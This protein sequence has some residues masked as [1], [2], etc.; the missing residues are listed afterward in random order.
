MAEETKKTAQVFRLV[1]GGDMRQTVLKD[2][3]PTGGNNPGD[4]IQPNAFEPEDEYQ[5]LYVGATR[6]QGIIQPPF[7]LRH[8][9]RLCQ[10][11]NTL[12]PCI[13]AM[14]TNIEGTGYDF[15]AEGEDEEDE[16]D[17]AQLDEL[18]EFFA[19]PWPA[20]SFREIRKLLRRDLERVG[21]G[22]LEVLRN[23]QDEIVFIRHVDAKM[24]RILRLDDAVPLDQTVMRKGATVSLKVMTRERRYCQ[25]VNGVSLM[26]FKEFGSKRDLHKKTA[27]WAPLG[28]RLPASMRATEI[29]HFTTILDSHTPYGVP[30][31]ISQMPSVLGSRK[32][33]EFNLEFFDNGGVPP[34]MIL[35]QGGTLQAET[36]QAIEEMTS[37]SAKENNR[38]RVLEVEP[39]TGTVD[40]ASKAT[41]HGR[42]VRRRPDQGQH[43]RDVR[44]EVRGARAPRVP[45][46]ADLPRA[47]R[48]LQFRD[49]LRLLHRHRSPGVQTRARRLR[50]DHDDAGAAGDGL[51]RLQDE[52]E[53]ARD[54]R[55][56]AQAAGHRG[57]PGHEP[58]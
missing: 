46:P 14:I 42:A 26:Y 6:D 52:V 31:W 41:H 39:T 27:V 28:Q 35:L 4:A 20:T 25:L 13:E 29:I 17:D 7:N 49:R 48:R 37:G 8:L 23:A 30:R 50:R 33:E 51:R 19:E 10:E 15:E 55:L 38:V 40:S 16:E 36:R 34:I 54:R 12:E 47:G 1:K 18:T 57:D 45:H 53:A 5:Q 21:N 11:N 24:M 44:P 43:V 9:D 56:H 58:G 3:G 2:L 32:A 22:F